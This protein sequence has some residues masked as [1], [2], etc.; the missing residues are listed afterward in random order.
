MTDGCGCNVFCKQKST[1]DI[2]ATVKK[3]KKWRRNREYLRYAELQNKPY[4]RK[5]IIEKFL[6]T[7]DGK[8][9]TDYK[10]YCFN[11]KV[12]AILVIWNRNAEGDYTDGVFMSPEWQFISR[13]WGSNPYPSRPSKLVEMVEYAECLSKPFYFVRTDLYQIGNNV[14]FG[15]LTFTCAGAFFLAE[16]PSELLDMSKLLKIPID[17]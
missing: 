7:P 15:E 11:G 3:M 8:L 9:P 17:K 14:I 4:Y 5:I 2:S 1:L 16:T 10:L 12:A 13:C 6:E